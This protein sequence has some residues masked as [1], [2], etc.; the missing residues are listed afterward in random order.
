MRQSYC[1]ISHICTRI[2][3][4]SIHKEKK[5]RLKQKIHV[6]QSRYSYFCLLDLSKILKILIYK[7]ILLVVLYSCKTGFLTLWEEGRQ[8]KG[9]L[10]KD[11]DAIIWPNR[12]ENEEGRRL[13]NE[14]FDIVPFT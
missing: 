11:P 13:H 2:T 7:I 8:A 1:Q 9:I 6:T 12:D 10:K 5:F 3:R 4:N 14:E